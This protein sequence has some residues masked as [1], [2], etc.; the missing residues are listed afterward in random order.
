MERDIDYVIAVAELKSISKAAETLYISQPSLS[1]YLSNLE[2]ELGMALFSRTVYGT[3][4]TEAGE[5]YVEYAKE[6]RLL[7]ST[8]KKKL[9]ELN[10]SKTEQIR[11]GMTLNA[12]SLSAFNVMEE[13]KKKYPDVSIQLFNLLSK[14]VVSALQEKKYDFVLGPKLNFPAAI[15]YRAFYKDF[16]ILV[17]PKRYSLEAFAEHYE[18][19]E[20]SCVDL[21][22]LPPMDYIFQEETTAVRR[23][24]D[25][26]LKEAHCEIIPK[27]VVSSSTLA[28]QAAENQLGCC[29]VALGHLAYVN[30]FSRLNFYQISTQTYS[31]SGVIYLQNKNF[32]EKENYCISCLERALVEGEEIILKRIMDRV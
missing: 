10:A 3:E 7:R 11:I 32:S 27:M 29:I 31:S 23:G 13:V 5:I 9:K 24:I 25:R 19:I 20:L 30:D 8:M 15:S 6:I 17:V 26:M 14:D 12:A 2:E 4:L 16:Y 22:E 21:K 1:R 28:I 18:G